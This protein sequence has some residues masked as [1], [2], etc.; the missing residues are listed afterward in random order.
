MR[1]HGL[2]LQLRKPLSDR[3]YRVSCD[4][5]QKQLGVRYE[6]RDVSRSAVDHPLRNGLVQRRPVLLCLHSPELDR[7]RLDRRR[8]R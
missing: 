6:L 5:L 3:K 7:L 8:Q 2:R 4:V 1:C